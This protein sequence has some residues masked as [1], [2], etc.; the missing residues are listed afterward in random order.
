MNVLIVYAHPIETSFNH[1]LLESVKNSLVEAGHAVKIADLYAE[2]FQCA[3]TKEDFVQ[4]ENKPMPA[5]IEAEKE[6]VEW[7]DALVFIF[8][9][10][11]WSVP[12]MLK[13]VPWSGEVRTNGSPSVALTPSS[14]ASVLAGINA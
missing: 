10:W 12:A 13:A 3:M 7:S 6:R 8:P 9:V 11:W 5:E 4:F 2:N 1:A 14:N